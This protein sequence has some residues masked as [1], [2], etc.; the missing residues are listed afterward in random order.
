MTFSQPLV[1]GETILQDV[2]SEGFVTGETGWSLERD[3][4][5]EF[6]DVTVRGIIVLGLGQAQALVWQDSN[7]NQKFAEWTRETAN[8][9]TNVNTRNAN[10]SQIFEY[11]GVNYWAVID[12]VQGGI[13]LDGADGFL[14][15][16]TLGATY[17]KEAWQTVP[18]AS[19]AGFAS[20]GP[21][22]K[23]LPDGTC[24]MRGGITGHSTV[25][26]TLIA[27]LPAGYRPARN[28]RWVCATE[29]TADNNHIGIDTA[30]QITIAKAAANNSWMTQV[31][32]S[33]I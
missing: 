23:L 9:D 1:A 27:T 33:T 3:G 21:Q 31:V 10:G 16:A 20:N 12:D 14:H 24:I 8:G 7:G 2:H 17:T 26:G 30:G 32:F 18:V 25:A 4:D 11:Q 22:V 13:L 28:G 6:N 15:H 19:G 5:A 29:G